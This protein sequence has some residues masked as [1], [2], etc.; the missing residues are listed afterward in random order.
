M[1]QRP[2]LDRGAHPIFNDALGHAVDISMGDIIDGIK[3][4][5]LAD[6]SFEAAQVRSVLTAI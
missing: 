2:K 6:Y 3:R 4:E 5:L 1:K